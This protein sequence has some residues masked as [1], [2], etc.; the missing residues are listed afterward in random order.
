LVTTATTGIDIEISPFGDHD[1][2][3]A[4]LGDYR[5][6]TLAAIAG[7]G[8]GKTQ[9]GYW[10]LYLRMLK[11]PG[12]G[13]LVAEPTFNMLAKILLNSSDPGR[14]TL[15]QWFQ[16][17]GWHPNYKAVDK[18]LETDYGKVYLASADNPDS[19]Q[20]A[21][22]KGAWLDEGGMMSL[23]AHQTALQRVSLFDGQ[24]LITTTPYNR[25][26]LKTEIVDKADGDYMHVEKWKSI[27]NPAFPK[28]VYEEMQ[29]GP[30]AMQAHRFRMMYD[31][32]FERPSGMIYG[33]FNADKCVI[34]PFPIPKSWPCYLG[35]DYGPVHTAVVWYAKSPVK[36]KEWP[37]GTWFG[38]REYLEGNKSI[39]QHVKDLNRLSKGEDIQRKVGSAVAAERQ[40]R[41]EYMEKGFYIQECKVNEVEV[42]I[43]RVYGLHM[44]NK[45]VYFK[46]VMKHTLA[47]KEDYRRKLDASQNPTDT[48][49]NKAEYHFMDAERYVLASG[50]SRQPIFEA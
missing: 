46:D 40:W 8:G 38:Y 2:Q 6:R 42:G 1:G 33:C 29:S 22:V 31:A 43:D 41:R 7:T 16:R 15:E 13:W 26:W 20:G 35:I 5:A 44:A 47:Q 14:P 34:E 27:A 39:E 50:T 28:H 21:A 11:Y 19:M 24:E 10:W 18:I 45:I 17:V 23:I 30:N 12:Y 4:I 32:D 25:G 3:E 36:Y 49:D 9:L 48:I 37:A